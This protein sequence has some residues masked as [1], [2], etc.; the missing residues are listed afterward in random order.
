MNVWIDHYLRVRIAVFLRDLGDW[1][2]RRLPSDRRHES[3]VFVNLHS[4]ADGIDVTVPA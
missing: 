2:G 3:T 1:F 4:V